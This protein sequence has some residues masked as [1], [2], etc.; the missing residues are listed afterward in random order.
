MELSVDFCDNTEDRVKLGLVGSGSIF[1][2]GM[3]FYL[4]LTHR[5]LLRKIKVKGSEIKY[6]ALWDRQKIGRWECYKRKST[7]GRKAD[8]KGI[9]QSYLGKRSIIVE[10]NQLRTGKRVGLQT[11]GRLCNRQVDETNFILSEKVKFTSL[12][13]QKQ[14]TQD[15]LWK[16]IKS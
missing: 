3:A 7:G 1:W 11:E 10:V 9:L 15:A 2:G 16:V 6:I 12:C 13:T 14:T 5:T 8:V 4:G